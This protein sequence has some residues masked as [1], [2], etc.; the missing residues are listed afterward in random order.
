MESYLTAEISA[1]AIRGNLQLLAE[2]LSEETK[3]CAVVKAD[4]YGL[5]LVNLLGVI[6]ESADCLGVATPQEA[7]ELRDLDYTRDVICLLP[8]CAW[9]DDKYLHEALGE[10]IAR[11]ITLTAVK[12]DDARVI[13]ES[14]KHRQM[15][16]T[17]HVEIDSG[18]LRG[19]VTP[20][21]SAKLISELA[22]YPDIRLEGLYTHFACADEADK[23]FTELQLK[24]FLEVA[25]PAGGNGKLILHAANS[26]ALIDM[27]QTHLDMVRP[28][29]AMYGYQPSTDIQ[30]KLPLQPALR[31]RS[32]LLIVKDAPVGAGCGYG[33]THILRRD[34]RLGVAAVGYA[35]GYPRNLSNT[36][37]MRVGQCYAP[38]L[39]R[40]SMDQVILDLTDAPGAKAGDQ[41]EIIS[42]DPDAPN[43]V[44]NLARLADTIPYEIT[45]GLGSRATRV[46]VD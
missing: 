28:G 4:C 21:D 33:L 13:A 8:P 37:V 36:A 41:V 44:G 5:G 3:L 15:S 43:S 22:S 34:S 7:I 30:R 14:A 39:G 6:A 12:L 16:A 19:G 27:P 26:A 11:D 2:Q 35:D 23:T 40:V 20:A 29:I 18:M 38:V 25:H 17:V 24:R 32:R 10:L 46:L 9:P 45:C 31:L 1:S 42:P